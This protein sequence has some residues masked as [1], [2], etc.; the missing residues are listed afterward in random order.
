MD[1]ILHI[2]HIAVPY[3]SADLTANV[4]KYADGNI[5]VQLFDGF[6]PYATLSVNLPE[7]A[8]LLEDNEFFVKS[9]SENEP[10]VEPLLSTGIFEDTG[11]RAFAGHITAS[12][13]RLIEPTD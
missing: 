11:K 6:S 10:L 3:G 7:D 5:A 9:W 4:T 2:G 1:T 8:H 13:W 12:I